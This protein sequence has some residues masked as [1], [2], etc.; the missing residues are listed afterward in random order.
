MFRFLA[1]FLALML[2]AMPA[3]ADEQMDLSTPGADALTACPLP[4]GHVLFAGSAAEKG[5]FYNKKARLLCLNADGSTAWEYIHPAE[6]NC[7]FVDARFL[8]DGTIGALFLN[9][10]DQTI[11]E[12]AIFKFSLG[13]ELLSG[14]L[15]LFTSNLSF[16]EANEKCI[17]FLISREDSSFER[18]SFVDWDGNLLFNL[19]PDTLI[20]NG[21][22]V[23]P[24]EDGLL[25][26]GKE[27]GW[28]APAKLVKLDF[29]GNV[30]WSETFERALGGNADFFFSPVARLSDGGFAALLREE[31]A[32]SDPSAKPLEEFYLIRFRPDG[33]ILWKTSASQ[34]GLPYISML[35]AALYD[36][37]LVIAEEN[38]SQGDKLWT[39]RWFNA[40]DGSP[41]GITQQPRPEGITNYTAQFVILDGG[42][43][44]RRGIRQAGSENRTAELDSAD[45]RLMKVPELQ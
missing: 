4:D 22:Q 29:A 31:V 8:E 24:A 39:Y 9:R 45:Q 43:W 27:S 13:G 19:E 30:L 25:L 6:G 21:F 12:A 11:K 15:D 44:V 36:E 35:D 26:V 2:F 34:L 37:Y 7:H 42:L 10:P 40:A 14:P 23:V 5:D 33:S 3:A 18:Y 38:I 32:P 41:A 20:G 16:C 1:F 28:P 17:L